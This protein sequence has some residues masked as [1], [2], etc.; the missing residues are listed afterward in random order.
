LEEITEAIDSSAVMKK[1][2]AVSWQQHRIC[3]WFRG[4]EWM[5]GFWGEVEP[6]FG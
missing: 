6:G 3:G 1:V 4:V 2:E 5:K